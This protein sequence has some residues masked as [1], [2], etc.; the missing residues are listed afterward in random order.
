MDPVSCCTLDWKQA[1]VKN[2]EQVDS[3]EIWDRLTGP[4]WQLGKSLASIG[5]MAKSAIKLS[6]ALEAI[7]VRG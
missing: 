5:S 1:I 3:A 4:D 6:T 2:S 7:L